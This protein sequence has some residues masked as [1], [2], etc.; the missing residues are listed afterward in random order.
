VQPPSTEGGLEQG[1][2]VFEQLRPAKAGETEFWPRRYCRGEQP[3]I[4]LKPFVKAL[5]D[6]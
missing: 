2:V 5:A 3:M 1:P 6:W 4:S